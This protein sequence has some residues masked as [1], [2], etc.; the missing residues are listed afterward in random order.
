MCVVI[1]FFIALW[2]FK[3]YHTDIIGGCDIFEQSEMY[4]T[5]VVCHQYLLEQLYVMYFPDFSWSSGLQLY[6]I[7]VQFVFHIL[8]I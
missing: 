5:T 8:L 6:I 4:H 3:F 2:L 7:A 1:V